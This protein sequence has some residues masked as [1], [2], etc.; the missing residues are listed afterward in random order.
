MSK[1]HDIEIINVEMPKTA[2]AEQPSND[3]LE[4]PMIEIKQLTKTFGT[5]QAL[6]SID[7]TIPKGTV[8]GFVGP[9]G[10]GKSTTM[11]I[12]AT[13]MIPTSGI[14][15]VDGFDVTKHPH[16]VRKRI[17]YMPDFFWCV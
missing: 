14:A 8:F 7:L 10:A 6:K 5:F 1:N 16:E 11:S 2:P 4:V 9:N 15:K 12:L 17:G 3:S 13:L